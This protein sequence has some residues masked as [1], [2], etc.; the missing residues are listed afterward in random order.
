MALTSAS[1]DGQCPP[2]IELEMTCNMNYLLKRRVTNIL[3]VDFSL[4]SCFVYRVL[5]C[6]LYAS[7]TIINRENE[8]LLSAFQ[9]S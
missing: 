3:G 2:L 7:L 9:Y 8:I 4:V 5:L 6:Y 1:L